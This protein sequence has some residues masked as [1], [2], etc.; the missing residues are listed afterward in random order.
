MAANDSNETSAS[1]AECPSTMFARGLKTYS[2]HSFTKNDIAVSEIMVITFDEQQF[3]EKCSL[4]SP[5]YTQTL[6][7]FD[8]I[9][10]EL[11]KKREMWLNRN[12]LIC[13]V[14]TLSGV[15]G[16]TEHVSNVI[17]SAKMSQHGTM[18]VVV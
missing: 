10:A 3:Q 13:A 4:M 8:K 17:G 1:G 14:K 11:F 18:L 5:A 9:A 15:T 6:C 16:S 2:A 12:L 7:D